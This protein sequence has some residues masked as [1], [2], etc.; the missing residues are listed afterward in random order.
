MSKLER[1]QIAKFDREPMQRM[2]W[3]L[4]DSRLYAIF[5]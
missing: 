2:I 3:K 4:I 5:N 1:N